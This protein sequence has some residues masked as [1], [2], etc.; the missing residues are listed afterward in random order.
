MLKKNGFSGYKGPLLV[1]VMDG[2]GISDIQEGNAVSQSYTPTLDRLM[3]E[4]PTTLLK[5]HG[6]AVGLPSD[7]DM[8]NSEVGHN[9][10]GAGQVFAQGA[11]LVSKAIETGD[12]FRAN[13]WTEIRENVVLHS[14]TLHFI[15]LFSDGNVHSHIDHLKAMIEKAKSEGVKTVRVHILLD[16]RDVGETSALE[17]VDP[18]EEFLKSVS[19]QGFD[20]RI[21]SGGGRMNITMDRYDADWSMV[22]RGWKSHVLG[23]GTVFASAHEAIETLRSETKAI[24]QDLGAFI[25]ADAGKPIGTIEDNDSVIFFN[26]RGD[27]AIEISKSFV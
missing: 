7:E 20:A 13:G 26:F 21:A 27:R 6:T 8:G 24:D 25:I 10:I 1:V 4:Y 16:G 19:T 14:S 17:Y 12:M 18:F 23:E 15:G 9:A 5:A 22:E 2:V 11:K 3:K